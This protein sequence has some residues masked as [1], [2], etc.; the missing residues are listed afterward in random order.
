MAKAYS[1]DL[2]QRV[3]EACDRG[4][5][6]AA[7]AGR[8]A[9]SESFVEKLK[10]RRREAG[11]L[12]PKPHAGGREPLLA[13][14]GDALRGLLKAKPD[15]TLE[16]IREALGLPVQISTLWYHLDRLGLTHKKKR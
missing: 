13:A 10:R 2:R 12:E 11:T 9:V 7:V 14:H 3:A 1:M 5:S 6:A 4:D 15:T 8:Y 16:E